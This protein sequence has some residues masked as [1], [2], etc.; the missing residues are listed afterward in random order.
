MTEKQRFAIGEKAL[1][2]ERKSNEVK[3][4]KTQMV[5]HAV[6]KNICECDGM[7]LPLYFFQH[8]FKVPMKIIEQNTLRWI[9]IAAITTF[10]HST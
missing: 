4:H 3:R 2:A 9:F 6:N 7:K 1:L 10:S 8:K 5:L